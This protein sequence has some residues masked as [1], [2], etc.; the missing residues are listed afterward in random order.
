MIEMPVTLL[1]QKPGHGGFECNLGWGDMVF[2]FFS[3]VSYN[4][5]GPGKWGSRFPRLLLDLC[6]HGVVLDNQ[7]DELDKELGIIYRELANYPLSA[8]VYDIADPSLPIPWETI[9]GEENNN[10]SHPW[11]TPRGGQSYFKIFADQIRVARHVGAGLL[12]ISPEEQGNRNTLWQRKEKG[13][14]YWKRDGNRSIPK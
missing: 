4:L 6:D 13:R 2:C 1:V 10:L 5:E 9:P 11:V 7:L 3:S 8:A 14:D 12:L